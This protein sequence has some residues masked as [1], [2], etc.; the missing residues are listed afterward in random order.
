M[1][2]S[3]CPCKEEGRSLRFCVDYRKLNNVTKA[4]TF[5]LPR[6]DDISGGCKFF[7]TLDLKSGY[8]QIRVHPDSQEKTAFVTHQGL[9]QFRV[10][11]FGLMN[12]PAVFQRLMQ[13]VLMGFNPEAGP[14]YI[15]VY[16]DDIL[17][18][19]K[20]LEEHKSHLEQVFKRLEDVGLKLNPKKCSFACQKVE[21]LGHIVMAEGLKPNPERIEAVKQF[22]E[23]YCTSVPGIS[24][25]L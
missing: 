22:K 5:P 3:D 1:V 9:Y 23:P 6:M 19:S 17:I 20:T 11:P 15:A 16:L 24:F 12:A 13:Q 7:S 14:D 25:I 10:M 4:D 8:W 2:Q 18:V 21:Y